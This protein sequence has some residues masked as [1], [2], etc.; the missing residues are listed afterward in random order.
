[1]KTENTKY[2]DF[3]EVKEQLSAELIKLMDHRNKLTAK[4]AELLKDLETINELCRTYETSS[5]QSEVYMTVFSQ[6]M[7]MERGIYTVQEA[8]RLRNELIEDIGNISRYYTTYVADGYMSYIDDL[9]DIAG[10]RDTFETLLSKLLECSEV[11]PLADI[12][13]HVFSDGEPWNKPGAEERAQKY[14][15][16]HNRRGKTNDKE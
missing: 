7:E 2:F 12:A 4:H 9:S 6:V 8:I 1:M 11:C 3:K 16:W 14:Y 13:I 15:W 5:E 10:Y